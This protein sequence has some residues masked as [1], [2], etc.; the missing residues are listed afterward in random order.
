MAT[1]KSKRQEARALHLRNKRRA[2]YK[3]VLL[4]HSDENILLPL[5]DKFDAMMQDLFKLNVK[6]LNQLLNDLK[7]GYIRP[8]SGELYKRMFEGVQYEIME[9]TILK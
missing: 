9:R 6:Y 2:R 5:T 7:V 4:A 8:F 1:K 3:K